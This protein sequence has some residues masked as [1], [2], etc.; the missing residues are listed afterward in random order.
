MAKQDASY[1]YD[2]APKGRFLYPNGYYE[3]EVESHDSDVHSEAGNRAFTAVCRITKAGKRTDD[4]EGNPV[5]LRFNIGYP[6]DTDAEDPKTWSKKGDAPGWVQR[7]V[8]DMIKFL[9][10]CG[11]AKGE[12]KGIPPWKLFDDVDGEKVIVKMG[13]RTNKKS[14]DDEQTYD[15][16][17][18]GEREPEVL[19]DSEGKV[20]RK[21]REEDDDDDDRAASKAQSRGRDKDDDDDDDD[22]DDRRASAKRSRK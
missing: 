2:D 8:A 16:F 12:G 15:F 3:V 21:K 14:G 5:F 13:K 4:F 17:K 7:N 11:L 19:G 9:V 6:E 1:D 20:T 22:D 18:V 10:K